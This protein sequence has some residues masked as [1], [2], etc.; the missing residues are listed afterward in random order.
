MKHIQKTIKMMKDGLTV[1][2]NPIYLKS[3]SADKS[4]EDIKKMRQG[5][6]QLTP[7]GQQELSLRGCR[8][9]LI[10][11]HRY[12]YNLSDSDI[13]R[14]WNAKKQYWIDH[15]LA[16]DENTYC[17]VNL[18]IDAIQYQV[19]I[20]DEKQFDQMIA[21]QIARSFLHNIKLAA[22]YPEITSQHMINLVK[23]LFDDYL[24]KADNFQ[25][26]REILGLS[27]AELSKKLGWS[28]VKHVSNI[29]TCA[30]PIQSQTELAIECLLR[31]EKKWNYYLESI[32]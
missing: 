12:M 8:T 19:C 25:K 24:K 23:K 11:F 2:T 26:S 14:L 6:G 31:R 1:I 7:A 13:R 4:S 29:E 22:N 27:Q 15:K 28:T 21:D 17:D 20:R 3:E 10:E 16:E 5:D 30:R 18:M 9:A 32:S